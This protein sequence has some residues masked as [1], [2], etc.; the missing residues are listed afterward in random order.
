MP[1]SWISDAVCAD[2]GGVVDGV[3]GKGSR[4]SFS[5]ARHSANERNHW[6]Q[7]AS[8]APSSDKQASVIHRTRQCYSN[9]QRTSS[10]ITISRTRSDMEWLLRW[11]FV[12]V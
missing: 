3:D 7:S 8:I 9:W 2:D 11:Y 1:A 6:R 10:S 5:A 4:G 12:Y